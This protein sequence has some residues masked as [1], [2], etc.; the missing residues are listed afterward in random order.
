MG[1]TEADA[2]RPFSFEAPEADLAD[3]CNRINATKWPE[4]EQVT[5]DSQGVQLDMIQK[6]ARYWVDQLKIAI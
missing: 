6:L 3:L 2:I 4:R 5:D 1:V